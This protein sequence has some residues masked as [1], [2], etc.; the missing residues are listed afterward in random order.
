VCEK[1]RRVVIEV[2]R[3]GMGKYI[4]AILFSF[5]MLSAVSTVNAGITAWNCDDDGDGAIVMDYAKTALTQVGI[6]DYELSMTGA[7][8]GFPGNSAAPA[9]VQGDFTVNGDPTVKILEDVSN[10]T[11][12]NW[13]DYHITFGM[14]QNFSFISSGLT[15]PAGWT[16]VT[17]AVTAGNIPNGG[18]A[19]YVGTIDY[20]MGAGS[21]VLMGNDG[22]FGFKVTFTGSTAFSTEQIPTPEPTTI[23][24]LGLGAISVIRR[25]R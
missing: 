7:Q 11:T 16:A 13:T 17:S 10:D 8:Y 4:S 15:M 25:R 12:F 18:P 2:R 22:L 19:G 23:I 3:V 5:L 24:L 21:P 1:Q 6:G 9:H 20:Y 14:V